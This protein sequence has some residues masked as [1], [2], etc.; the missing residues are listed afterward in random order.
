MHRD[1][2]SAI[3]LQLLDG[4]GRAALVAP[5]VFATSTSSETRAAPFR[6]VRC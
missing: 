1:P 3:C 4:S 2:G 5:V 6:T